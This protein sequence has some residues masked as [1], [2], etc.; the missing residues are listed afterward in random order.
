[1]R[2]FAAIVPPPT[3]LDQLELALGQV[4][5]PRAGQWNPLVPR[6][7]WHITLAFF[8]QVP[9]GHVPELASEFGQV[10]AGTE[11]FDLELAGAGSFAGRTAWIGVG[12]DN[13]ALKALVSKVRALWPGPGDEDPGQSHRPHLTISRQALRS[14]LGDPLKALAIYRGPSWTVTTARLIESRL[15]EG[16]GGH[17]RYVTLAE[18]PLRK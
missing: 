17:A 2:V 14:D 6:A 11:P 15:G 1:M 4:I 8:G 10:V 13:T 9:A 16:V 18:E 7:S 3:V 5:G 12:G